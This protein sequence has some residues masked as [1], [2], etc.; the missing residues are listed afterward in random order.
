MYL[1]QEKKVYYIA[2]EIMTSEKDYVDVLRLLYID[3]R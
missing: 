1:S 2:R 3:F